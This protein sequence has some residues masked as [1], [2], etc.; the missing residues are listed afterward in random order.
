[1]SSQCPASSVCVGGGCVRV[2]V[3]PCADTAELALLASSPEL[4]ARKGALFGD[5]FYVPEWYAGFPQGWVEP[6]RPSTLTARVPNSEGEPIVGC[7]V[8]FFAAEGSGHG[9]ASDPFSNEMGEVS[10]LW[11]AGSAR[12]QQ[13]SAAVRAENGWLFASLEGEARG[14]DEAP[15]AQGPSARNY[16]APSGVGVRPAVNA[17]SLDAQVTFVP[18]TFP[19]QVTYSILDTSHIAVGF[20]NNGSQ[21]PEHE[22]LVESDRV[23]QLRIF[24]QNEQ[25]V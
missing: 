8:K 19:A 13:I 4:R 20:T 25:R 18:I 2:E 17:P 7:E 14:H 5:E 15:Q 24:D 22:D 3:D 1:E 23:L 12:Y 11:V 21:D 10:A 16:T 6:Y 9:F